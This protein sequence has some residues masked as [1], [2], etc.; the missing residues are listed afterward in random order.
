MVNVSVGL[1]GHMDAAAYVN[2]RAQE[3][4]AVAD[5]IKVLN[6]DGPLKLF[7]KAFHGNASFLQLQVSSSQMRS[8]GFMDI[9]VTM[10]ASLEKGSM[11]AMGEVLTAVWI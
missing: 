1:Y 4:A 2:C 10:A 6:N 7:N 5:T 8:Q 11:K 3:L 9:Q